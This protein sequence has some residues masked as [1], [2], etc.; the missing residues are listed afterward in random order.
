MPFFDPDWREKYQKRI[1]SAAA[2]MQSIRPGSRV[3]I[4]SGAAEPQSLVKALTQRGAEIIDTEI[5]HLMTLGSA[6]Y[7]DE[8]FKNTFR[9][10]ALFVGANVRKAVG[11]GRA[12]YTPVFLSEIPRLFRTRRLGLDAALIQISPPDHHGFCSFGVSVDIVKAAAE[13]ADVV[14]AEVNEKMPRVLGDSFIHINNLDYVVDVSSDIPESF[15]GEPDEIER[16]IGRNVASLVEDGSTIQTGIGNIPHAVMM[17]LTHKRDLGVHTELLTDAVID[18]IDSG[19]INGRKKTLLPGKIVA[20]FCF[21]SQRLYEYIDNNP[22]FEF[23]SSL[24]T[25][26]PMVIARNDRMV[27]INAALE[28]DLT[29]QICSDSIGHHFYSGIGG[30]VDF[31]R[32]AARSL[33]GK[34][35]IAL[36]STAQNGRVSRIVPSLQLGAG[37]VTTRGDVHYVVTEYGVADLWGKSVRERALALI[38]IAH[39]DFREELLNQAKKRRLVYADQILVPKARYPHE[40]ETTQTNRADQQIFYRPVKPTDEAMLKEMFYSLSRKTIFQRYMFSRTAMPHAKMQKLCNVDYKKNMTLVAILNDDSADERIVGVGDY[41]YDPA[42]NTADVAFLVHDD[43]QSNGIGTSLLKQLISIAIKNSI[44]GF[45]A[46]VLASNQHMLHV[47]NKSGYAVRTTFDDGL[48]HIEFEFRE[49]L[50]S[51][52]P[53]ADRDKS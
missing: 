17:A 47:F 18:L 4:G 39:P 10:N 13:S 51:E 16:E 3:F 27:A 29:G 52:T 19:V 45:T 33:E 31:V 32:G 26:D 21:G 30:Q 14:I 9:H 43:F 2:A 34:P 38:N 40:Y 23:R 28:V 11:E 50:T 35:I 36:R 24:F 5:I 48:Y 1:V 25:N 6:P 20:S 12:D 7:T 15:P 8:N 46:D 42:T 41:S 44:K 53:K 49:P 37:V 22:I